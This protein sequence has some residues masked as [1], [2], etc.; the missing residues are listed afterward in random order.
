MKKVDSI[1]EEIQ[2]V[3]I[4]WIVP[5]IWKSNGVNRRKNNDSGETCKRNKHQQTSKENL[6]KNQPTKSIES[7]ILN[8]QGSHQPYINYSIKI[9][10][11]KNDAMSYVSC[12]YVFEPIFYLGTWL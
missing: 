2:T 12:Y 8:R 7:Q 11:H 6:N 9:V 10:T 5:Q 3:E 1:L 4:L